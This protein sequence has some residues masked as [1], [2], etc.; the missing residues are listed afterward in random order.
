MQFFSSPS[1]LM[2]FTVLDERLS[3]ATTRVSVPEKNLL[4][5]QWYNRREIYTEYMLLFI[6]NCTFQKCT[7]EDDPGNSCQR[8]IKESTDPLIMWQCQFYVTWL[9]GFVQ[10]EI[11]NHHQVNSEQQTTFLKQ[12]PDPGHSGLIKMMKQE[13]TL[14]VSW[15]P[16]EI[17][18]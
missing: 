9:K 11:A 5:I 2:K 6:N 15:I 12:V 8:I 18:E 16:K 14:D 3:T 10:R 17:T 4:I 1:D 7:K 13:T